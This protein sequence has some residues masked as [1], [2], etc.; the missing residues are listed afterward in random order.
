MVLV[1]VMTLDVRVVEIVLVTF[2]VV[3]VVVG[4]IDD[5]DDEV[6]P[7]VPIFSL[8]KG[9]LQRHSSTLNKPWKASCS[10]QPRGD[11]PRGLQVLRHCNVPFS[12]LTI[13]N[14]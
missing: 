3:F 13:I 14:E 10:L 8:H 11:S 7:I 4:A 2:V 1:V 5:D 6:E 9:V 12:A